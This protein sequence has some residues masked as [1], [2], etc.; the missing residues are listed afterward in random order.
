M[1]K[2]DK[3]K[4]FPQPPAS[5]DSE[6]TNNLRA[7]IIRNKKYPR[8]EKKYDNRYR[9]KDIKEALKRIYSNK[10]AYCEQNI[11]DTYF[12]IEHYRPKDIYY[13]LA[14]S[15]DNLL[16]CCTKCNTKKGV[17]FEI[18]AEERVK[19][20]EGDLRDLHHLTRKYNDIEKPLL[21]N[22]E[23]E[24]VED[25]LIFHWQTG[26]IDSNDPRCR[27]TIECCQLYR[28]EANEN[29]QKLW[30]DF[31]KQ[32]LVVFYRI[33][34]LKKSLEK[35]EIGEDD[36]KVKHHD[37]MVELEVH[38]RCFKEAANDESKE[39][40]AFRRYVVRNHKLFVSRCL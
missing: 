3:D 8:G 22:P 7:D 31:Y 17:Q 21:V 5:L 19:I 14:Y 24:D 11:N 2:V 32:I 18:Q 30:D 20:E 23:L 33:S 10:C 26:D 12:H 40:L 36:Y 34:I 6:T 38:I 27:Y 39:Y 35:K 1:R 9:M 37:Y 4:L 15:W 25:K 16:L 28:K 29:R 13:W